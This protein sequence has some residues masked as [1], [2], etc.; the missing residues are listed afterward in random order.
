[1]F[2]ITWQGAT[3]Y[4]IEN[5]TLRPKGG[6]TVTARSKKAGHFNWNELAGVLRRVRDGYQGGE[7][8]DKAAA[9][10]LKWCDEWGLFGVFLEEFLEVRL[11][12]VYENYPVDPENV[13]GHFRVMP[14]QKI[15]RRD[16]GRWLEVER[17]EQASFWL[18]DGEPPYDAAAQV[19]PQ[20][21]YD[22]L[23]DTQVDHPDWRAGAFMRR[24]GAE[25]A[26]G[27]SLQELRAFFT[28]L[29]QGSPIPQP[30]SPTFWQ[31]YSEPVS[32]W[33]WAAE[34]MLGSLTQAKAGP[35][36]NL[37]QLASN[38]QLRWI[39]AGT[40]KGKV[41]WVAA[42]A[43]AAMAFG[44]LLELQAGRVKVCQLCKGPFLAKGKLAAE[45]KWCSPQCFQTGNKRKQ[46]KAKKRR[47]IR[48]V[49]AI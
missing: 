18:W 37:E 48:V 1:M 13:H 26:V 34:W 14:V 33:L 21:D 6:A 16:G 2:E 4:T 30:L 46:R 49:P 38:G 35:R 20:P 40:Q 29:P 25:R 9:V 36:E 28:G 17:N 47:T 19:A 7:L 32:F 8:S 5:Q 11:P 10:L 43:M 3:A 31:H 27:V 39:G 24:L 15:Y 22:D 45:R 23:E 42:S 12:A 41:E 44:S